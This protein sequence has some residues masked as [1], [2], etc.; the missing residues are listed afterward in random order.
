MRAKVYGLAH[1]T[2]L[3]YYYLSYDSIIFDVLYTSAVMSGTSS[4]GCYYPSNS[5]G[6]MSP[7]TNFNTGT[8]ETL[9][10]NDNMFYMGI[11]SMIIYYTGAITY[12]G[13]FD[14]TTVT[15]NSDSTI[16]VDVGFSG[17]AL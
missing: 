9:S 3:S 17:N 13:E 7:T 2:Y 14:I 11:S 16:K 12:K 10:Y 6:G 8:T 15:Q 4:I 5:C 1:V